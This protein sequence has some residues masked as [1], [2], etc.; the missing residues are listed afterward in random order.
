MTI[1]AGS[2]LDLNGGLSC[3]HTALTA[4]YIHLCC[5]PRVFESFA[6]NRKE[7]HVLLIVRSL[8]LRNCGAPRKYAKSPDIGRDTVEKFCW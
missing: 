5:Y 8:R 6:A 2:Q 4:R 1:I 7:L 3:E